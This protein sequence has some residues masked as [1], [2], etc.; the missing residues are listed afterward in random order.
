MSDDLH[1]NAQRVLA[2]A[3][4]LGLDVDVRSYPEG[5]R[6][7]SDAARAIGVDV[8]AIVKSLVLGSDD[9]PVLALV[10]GANRADLDA[11]GTALGVS[12][13][14]QADAQTAR[15]ATG[16]PVGGTPPLAHP[17]ALPTVVD[18]HLLAY[19]EVWAAAGTPS[20]VFSVPPAALVRATSATVARIAG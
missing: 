6:T 8:G 2:A 5:T 3:R 7:A 18:T 11:V 13:V 16:F 1:P 9:G 20:L 10:S 14:H 17:T 12:G 19:D 4:E 15:D